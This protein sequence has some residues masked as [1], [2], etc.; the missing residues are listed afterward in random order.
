L[1]QDGLRHIFPH[2]NFNALTTFQRSVT[3]KSDAEPSISSE[4]KQFIY[5]I[6]HF[7]PTIL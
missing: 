2:E 1:P 6:F 7:A 3:T 5:F 4:T